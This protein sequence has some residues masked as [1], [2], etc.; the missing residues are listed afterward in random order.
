MAS[1]RKEKQ[2][3]ALEGMLV[4]ERQPCPPKSEAEPKQN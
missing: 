4:R 3:L 1:G 2:R